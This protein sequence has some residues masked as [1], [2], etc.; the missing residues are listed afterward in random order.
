[1][2][3]ESSAG[4]KEIH[5]HS[6]MAAAPGNAAKRGE[7]A[8]AATGVPS[9]DA[10]TFLELAAD[11]TIETG[12]EQT[13]ENE[14]AAPHSI[15]EDSA[16][17]IAHANFVRRQAQLESE[18]E[19]QNLNSLREVANL[20]A[21]SALARHASTELKNTLLVQGIVTGVFVAAAIVLLAS[22][23]W[24]STSRIHW[25]ILAALA[26]GVMVWQTLQTTARMQNHRS[27]GKSRKRCEKAESADAVAGTQAADDPEELDEDATK[28]QP[29]E[30]AVGEEDS[31]Q[32]PASAA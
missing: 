4:T 26:S 11:E 27:A 6:D 22:P 21:R 3:A 31:H 15:D 23:M 29:A 7:T 30:E 14:E 1:R 9:Q 28:L 12:V 16:E 5:G 13:G 25:G 2:V 18:R 8:P 19:R 10:E 24:S 20:S 32:A 17:A